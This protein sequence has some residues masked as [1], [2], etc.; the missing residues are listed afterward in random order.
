[1][2]EGKIKSWTII[3]SSVCIHNDVCLFFMQDLLKVYKETR[4]GML[5]PDYSTKFSPWLAFGCIS[6]RFIYEEVRSFIPVIQWPK[7]YS[8]FQF[9]DNRNFL[10][11]KI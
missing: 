7:T 11:S 9:S 3:S 4:N 8:S 2:E 1:M 5:G 6:P 10:G